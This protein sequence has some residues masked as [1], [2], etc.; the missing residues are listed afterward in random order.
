[1]DHVIAMV[2][3][4]AGE[5]GRIAES[6]G[7]SGLTEPVRCVPIEDE[8]ALASLLDEELDAASTC[9]LLVSRALSERVGSLEALDS[10]FGATLLGRRRILAACL[11]DERAPPQELLRIA[12]RHDAIADETALSGVARRIVGRLARMQVHATEAARGRRNVPEGSRVRSWLIGIIVVLL[13]LLAF[14]SFQKFH[15]G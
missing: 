9:V 15:R 13:A 11:V 1:M 7:A 12:R 3:E 5:A 14:T 4:D 10:L 6:I 2:P 8:E